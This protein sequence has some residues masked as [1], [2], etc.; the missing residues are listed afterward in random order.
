MV[1]RVEFHVAVDGMCLTCLQPW[2]KLPVEYAYKVCVDERVMILTSSIESL[3]IFKV[4][5][6][7]AIVVDS[8]GVDV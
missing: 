6:E 2:L 8:L 1:G 5:D 7:V 3:C 4:N